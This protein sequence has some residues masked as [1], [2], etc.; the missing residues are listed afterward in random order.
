MGE[1]RK[2]ALR[3]DFDSQIKLEFHGA[4]VTSDAGLVAYREL[5]EMLGLTTS[6]VILGAARTHSMS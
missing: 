3:V 1:A 6:S 2:E 4:S 5:D